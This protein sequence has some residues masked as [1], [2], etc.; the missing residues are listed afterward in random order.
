ML[1]ANKGNKKNLIKNEDIPYNDKYF[2]WRVL[3]AD[4]I[5]RDNYTCQM[6]VTY[7]GHNLLAL[8]AHHIVSREDNGSDEPRNLITLCGRCHDIAEFNKLNHRQIKSYHKK[9]DISKRKFPPKSA[10]L[11]EELKY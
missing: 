11:W 7:F 1:S 4:I 3:K 2:D 8:T 5:I 6:C 9:T 10:Y